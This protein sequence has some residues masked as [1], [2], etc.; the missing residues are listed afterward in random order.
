MITEIHDKIN[1]LSKFLK[2]NLKLETKVSPSTSSMIVVN[3]RVF[4][5]FHIITFISVR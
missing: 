1:E 4:D 2:L 3:V 5:I